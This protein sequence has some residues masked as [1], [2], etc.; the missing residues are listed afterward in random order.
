MI[1]YLKWIEI[2]QFVMIVAWVVALF[3]ILKGEKIMPFFLEFLTISLIF[4]LVLA[5]YFA[6]VYRDNRSVLCIFTFICN[7]Y[8]LYILNDYF[9]TKPWIRYLWVMTGIWLIYALVILIRNISK[10]E[11]DVS[12]YNLGMILACILILKYFYDVV[13]V[14]EF[15][16]VFKESIFY[17]CVGILIFYAANFT[18]LVKIQ[19]LSEYGQKMG[20]TFFSIL[21]TFGNIILSSG[22]LG[23]ALCSR[24]I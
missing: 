2:Y 17:F 11:L 13:Y 9:R 8:Y 16:N 6:K 3:R 19:V 24:K 10:N 14:D 12:G 21:R 5:Y 23:A 22:Y 4:E 7:C 18:L 20:S 15:K 1:N